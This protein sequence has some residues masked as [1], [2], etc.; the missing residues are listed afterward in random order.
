MESLRIEKADEDG[1]IITDGNGDRCYV[2]Y[3]EINDLITL[4]E[5]ITNETRC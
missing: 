2:Y 4:L 5:G 1:I 3:S